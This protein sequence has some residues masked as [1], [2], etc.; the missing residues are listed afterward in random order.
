MGDNTNLM[1]NCV[2]CRSEHKIDHQDENGYVH[3][4]HDAVLC[5]STGNYGSTEFDPLHGDE[6]LE[7]IVCDKCLVE[8]AE[9]FFVFNCRRVHPTV[10]RTD[11]RTYR[12][13]IAREKA[14]DRP[15]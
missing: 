8:R 3:S 1:M 13:Q 11:R 2:I 14:H 4:V 5:D 15:E 9:L 12:E 6:K 7:F 10:I